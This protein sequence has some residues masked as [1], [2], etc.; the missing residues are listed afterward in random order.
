MNRIRQWWWARQSARD[1]VREHQ[2]LLHVEHF[3]SHEIG[4]GEP[5]GR[6]TMS[7][8]EA[9]ETLSGAAGRRI[10]LP[11]RAV[12]STG[13]ETCAACGAAGP[14]WGDDPRQKLEPP[15]LHQLTCDSA[16]GAS[17][18]FFCQTCFAGWIEPDDPE[19]ITWV[20]PHWKL[21]EVS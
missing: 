10:K 2:R 18:S 14:M 16:F 5:R 8:D 7:L 3:T 12:V 1:S 21:G 6:P 13:P 15:Q 19:P 11:Q 20:R 4:T 9:N 17:D